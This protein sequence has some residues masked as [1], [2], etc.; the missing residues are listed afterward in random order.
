MSCFTFLQNVENLTDDEMVENWKISRREEPKSLPYYHG[1]TSNYQARRMLRFEAEGTF[2]VRKIAV[3]SQL[4]LSYRSESERIE[5]FKIPSS[6]YYT[7]PDQAADRT[8]AISRL[9]HH[10]QDKS[11]LGFGLPRTRP[12]RRLKPKENDSE[13]SVLSSD[14]SESDNLT[15]DETKSTD[16][17]VYV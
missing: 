17:P 13:S 5:H 1:L 14:F 3:S 6:P 12:R 10:L 8:A 4:I 2:L 15:I 7:S 9:V 16:S 11:V